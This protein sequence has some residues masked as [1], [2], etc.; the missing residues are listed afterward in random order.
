MKNIFLAYLFILFEL[1]L[2]LGAGSIEF[3]PNWIGYFFLAKAFK[4]LAGKSETFNKNVMITEGMVVVDLAMWGLDIFCPEAIIVIQIP[5]K[6]LLKLFFY[7]STYNVVKGIKEIEKYHQVDIGAK[8]MDVAWKLFVGMRLASV[9]A[10]INISI[11]LIVSILYFVARVYQLVV[12]NKTRK[13]YAMLP[14]E[15]SKKSM[16]EKAMVQS[17][18]DI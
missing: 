14:Q 7:T 3:F 15:V 13:A 16:K 11:W 17:E 5:L 1:V 4:E 9:I 10:R 18:Q 2:P 12:I 6:F 8:K